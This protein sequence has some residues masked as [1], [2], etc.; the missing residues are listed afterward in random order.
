MVFGETIFHLS[1]DCGPS[2]QAI[3]TPINPWG[4]TL[5]E[6]LIGEGYFD[7]SMDEEQDDPDGVEGAENR[8]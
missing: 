8:L 1:N 5:L 3:P 2:N 4:M 7:P 6:D